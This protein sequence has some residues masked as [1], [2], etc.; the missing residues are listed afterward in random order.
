MHYQYQIT[1]HTLH[2]R[3]PAGTSRGIYLERKVWYVYLSPCEAS[4]IVGLGEC[5][6]LKALSC[7]DLLN[8]ETLLRQAVEAVATTGRIDYDALRPYPSI[9]M[10]L[11]TA[12][13]SCQ[14]QQAGRTALQ[15]FDTP[16]TRGEVGI[17]T[18]GLVWMGTREEMHQRIADKLSSG[19]RCIKLKIGAIDFE[20]ELALVRELREKYAPEA[21]EIRLDANGAFAVD[22]ALEKLL[23]LSAFHI[24]S[25]EQPIR[26]GQW[27][28]MRLL[29]EQSP[30]AIALDEEL[31]GVNTLAEKQQLL[32]AI[33]PPF[34][35]LKPSLH[36]GLHGAEEWMREAHRRNIGFWVTSALESNVGLNAIAQWL[37]NVGEKYYPAECH[38]WPYQGLGTG[39]LFTNNFRG[40]RLQVEGNDLWIEDE[41]QRLFRQ[42]FANFK[43]EWESKATTLTV[44][45]SGSTGEPKPMIVEKWRM[46]A[47]A[48]KTCNFLQLTAEDTAL[49][50]LPLDFI[51]GKMMAVRAF[52]RGFRLELAA[53]SAHPFAHVTE[54]PTFVAM[55]PMQVFETLNSPEEVEVLKGVRH[56]LIG[57]G[58]IT[59]ALEQRLQ[60][61]VA[62]LP[63]GHSFHAWS[64]YGMTETLSHVALRRLCA[65]D[66]PKGYVPLAGVAITLSSEGGISISAP[67]VCPEPLQ[68]NDLGEWLPDGSLRILGRV[69]NIVCSGGLKLQIEVL[70]QQ[71]GYLGVPF[72][73]T[74]VPDARLGEALTLVYEGEGQN[75]RLQAL[76]HERLDRLQRPLYIIGVP[77]LPMTATS[78]VARKE[79]RELALNYQRTD[80]C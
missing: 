1:P 12:L 16:F 17:P 41:K 68:T 67:D 71:L 29:C 66:A 5:A 38:R 45:T 54:S 3:Q 72:A 53:P 13:L 8:Y 6:P 43:A 21:L 33:R 31:I 44:H 15:L 60:R 58:A 78:K 76:C 63:N 10:G 57:G 79:L 77:R 27:E 52:V 25:I 4:H 59:E 48:E 75:D 74:A 51:A 65:V 22:E 36:G 30:I 34:I 11:E 24:H 18:N 32:D 62:S 9:L 55:T 46:Q 35:I 7:D 40:T 20:E 42:S 56:L 47:S 69:D 49:L 14:A 70:E 80:K 61:F 37:S 73:L 19:S 28:A 23:R 39:A 50:C 2:F 26:A 64:S